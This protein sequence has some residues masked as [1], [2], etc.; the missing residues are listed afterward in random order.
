MV[1]SYI[2]YRQKL[3]CNNFGLL[4]N[5][6]LLRIKINEWLSRSIKALGFGKQ[7]QLRQSKSFIDIPNLI[8]NEKQPI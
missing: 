2:K 7:A 8:I 6:Q 3:I 4:F 5:A 1:S